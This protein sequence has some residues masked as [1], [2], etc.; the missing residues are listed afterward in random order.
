MGGLLAL[1]IIIVMLLVLGVDIHLIIGGI[2]GLIGLA[3]VLMLIFFI[4]CGIIL[5]ST[6]K[7]RAVFSRIGRDKHDVFDRAYYTIDGEE[8]P[9]AFPCE[10]AFRESIYRDD[11][12]VN[13]RLT[14]GKKYV[15]DQNAY[16][17]CIVGLFACIVI[18]LFGAGFAMGIIAF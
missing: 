4:V 3:L 15:F 12:E 18:C 8:Y 14:A 16:L 10:V 6:K 5:L 11:R 9:N 2:L 7:H 17:T 1:V 13:V